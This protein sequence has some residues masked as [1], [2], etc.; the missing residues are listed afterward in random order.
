MPKYI[1]IT[2]RMSRAQSRPV[3]VFHS[4]VSTA[5]LLM[6]RRSPPQPPTPQTFFISQQQSINAYIYHA[7]KVCLLFVYNFKALA[8]VDIVIILMRKSVKCA[9]HFHKRNTLCET[10]YSSLNTITE[11]TLQVGLN[12]TVLPNCLYPPRLL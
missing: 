12:S 10:P 1:H 6:E 5:V 8:A 3:R 7:F 2:E 4:I 11:L 9:T